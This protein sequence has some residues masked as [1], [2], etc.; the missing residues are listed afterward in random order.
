MIDG[1]NAVIFT[2]QEIAFLWEKVISPMWN[3]EFVTKAQKDGTL[4]TMTD[5][6]RIA[7]NYYRL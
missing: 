1:S 7:H 2:K 4:E 5:M 3:R 6:M